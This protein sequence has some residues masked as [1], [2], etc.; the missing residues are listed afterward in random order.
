MATISPNMSSLRNPPR[1]VTLG[2][3]AF[4]IIVLFVTLTPRSPQLNLP[5]LS[6]SSAPSTNGGGGSSSQVD[7]SKKA[8]LYGSSTSK[9]EKLY[10]KD[11]HGHSSPADINRVTNDT[12]GFSK[13][14]VIGLPER[15]DKRD[16][17]S[18]TSSLTGF[19]VE[20]VDGVRGET[21]P[22]KAVPFGADRKKLWENNLG[23]WRGH[24]NAIRR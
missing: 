10:G 14:F 1:H 3:I 22:D 21:I 18:L 11:Y 9:A 24:M 7:P 16:A 5:Q 4:I 2:G 20:W 19:H 23:S 13:V 8:D 15:S 12:L 17:I 6:S